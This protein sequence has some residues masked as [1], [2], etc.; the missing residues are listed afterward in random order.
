MELYQKDKEFLFEGGNQPIVRL[1]NTPKNNYSQY[2]LPFMHL[3]LKEAPPLPL[4]PANYYIAD[5]AKIPN[6]AK[7]MLVGFV[8]SET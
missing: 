4:Q 2:G 6:W 7:K 5:V 1:S 3:L 8:F